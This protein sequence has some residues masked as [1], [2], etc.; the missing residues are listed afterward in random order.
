MEVSK[1][2]RPLQ[3]IASSKGDN[4]SSNFIMTN[5]IIDAFA[6]VDKASVQINIVKL[7]KHPHDARPSATPDNQSGSG[8]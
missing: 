3:N 7:D 5:K 2:I 8:A 6:K 1:V 4:S